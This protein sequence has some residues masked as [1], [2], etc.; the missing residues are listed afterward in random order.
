MIKFKDCL[1]KG[2]I[3][4]STESMTW[5]EKE[6][7]IAKKYNQSAKTVLKI[8]ENNLASLSAYN[9]IMH[10]NRAL[11]FSKG[12]VSKNHS[13]LISAINEL[14]DDKELLE[15][16]NS[17]QNIL[18]RRN[19]IQYDGLDADDELADFFLKNN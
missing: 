5:I 8:D 15:L 7:N 2:F 12:Y 6:I 1:E 19:N 11:I 4:K 10:L 14:F 17:F 9:S 3:K 16:T 13:C 18:L